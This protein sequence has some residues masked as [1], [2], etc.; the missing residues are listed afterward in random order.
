MVIFHE[1]QYHFFKQIIRSLP[2]VQGW[3]QIHLIKYK[4]D[5]IEFFKYKYNY[6]ALKNITYKNISNTNTNA[7]FLKISSLEST[8]FNRMHTYSFAS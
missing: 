8:L 3:G 4:Y 5:D 7:I 2:Q 6:E 1:N